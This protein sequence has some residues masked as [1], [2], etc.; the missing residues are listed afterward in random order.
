MTKGKFSGF[1][2]YDAPTN[3]MTDA[4]IDY[5]VSDKLTIR[6]GRFVGPACQA[7]GRTSHTVIDFAERSIVGRLW[8]KAVGRSDYR[9][10]GV[11]VKGKLGIINYE[12]MGNNGEG[13]KNIKPYNV[14][15]DNSTADTGI[16]PQL[17]FMVYS[18][19]T[20]CMSAGIHYG[21]P[22]EKRLN[23][24]SFTGYFHYKPSDYKKGNFRSKVDFAMVNNEMDTDPIKSLGYG[25]TGFYRFSNA[26]E[27]GLGYES[28]DPNTDLDDDAFAN[29][30]MGLTYSLDPDNWK[31]ALIKLVAT[32]K[33][34]QASTLPK[35]P[36][37]IHLI[38][39]I[40]MH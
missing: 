2:Q 15:S 38:W 35:D 5:A 4:Q 6:L 13:D 9:T 26:M 24:S 10:F 37:I 18:K 36:L 7:G 14:K 34:A 1:F 21:L 8:A 28:W 3:H 22:N 33:T 12:I 19:F 16:L 30:Y 11:S 23:I 39:Q 29:I 27:F 32:I 25:I 17:D 20:D 40:Y 31:D